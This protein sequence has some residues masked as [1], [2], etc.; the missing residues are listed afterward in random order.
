MNLKNEKPS[1]GL[2]KYQLNIKLNSDMDLNTR[3]YYKNYKSSKYEGDSG[4]DL[5]LP[6]DI[7]ISKNGLETINFGITCSMTKVKKSQYIDENNKYMEVSVPISYYLYPRSSISSMG[8]MLANSVGIIDQG[9]RGN[10]MAKIRY[11]P[12]CTHFL[13]DLFWSWW[14]S[15][16][17]LKKGTKLFQIC[18][19]NLEPFTINIVDELDETERGANGFGSSGI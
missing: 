4:F 9:Y 17:S 15:S 12:I 5:P 1:K 16:K 3:E 14:P 13:W 7:K 10:I 19:P 11:I 6:Q 2:K 18:A 8:I